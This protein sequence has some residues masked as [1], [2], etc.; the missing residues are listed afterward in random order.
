[1]GLV[2]ALLG[3]GQAPAHHRD[4]IRP[5]E[6]EGRNQPYGRGRA[7]YNI[8][9]CRPSWDTALAQDPCHW[10][11]YGVARAR[12]PIHLQ[13]SWHDPLW[14][15]QAARVNTP[16]VITLGVAIRVRLDQRILSRHS[17]PR[18]TGDIVLAS[19]T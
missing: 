7:G 8:V 4:F 9:Q 12:G 15:A 16:E 2:P 19:V 14:V 3:S 5:A 1:M 11:A 18:S 6:P 17:W 13:A 10:T